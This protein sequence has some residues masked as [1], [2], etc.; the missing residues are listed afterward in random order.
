MH[1]KLKCP[2]CGFEGEFRLLKTWRFRFYEVKRLKCS[3]CKGIFNHYYGTSPRGKTS[4]FV[5]RI[6][7]KVI[8][9]NN[10][11]MLSLLNL[12]VH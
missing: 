5:I 12:H 4:Q 6:K 10:K 2:Y 9:K 3:Q 1:A 8:T 11:M 7:P